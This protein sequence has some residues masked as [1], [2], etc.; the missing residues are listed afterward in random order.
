MQ[1]INY[2]GFGGNCEEAFNFYAKVFKK[3]ISA[4]FPNEGTPAE[5]HVPPEW[6][7]KIMHARLDVAEGA[8]LMGGD[9]PMGQFTK[10]SGF[11]INIAI[12]DADEAT[13]IFS[14]LAEGGKTQ[15][16][17]A[18]TFWAKL[19]GMCIDKYGVP[20]MVNVE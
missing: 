14:E 1:F 19:F 13:R 4:M 7:K 12:K 18:Q 10:H 15:M 16:P 9:A 8:T 3:E 5:A 20:W 17:L 11:C 6:K 2:L